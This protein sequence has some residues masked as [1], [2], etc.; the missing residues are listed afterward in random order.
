MFTDYNHFKKA[1]QILFSETCSN[2]LKLSQYRD[3]VAQLVGF[4]NQQSI[5]TYFESRSNG[6][7]IVSVI[8]YMNETIHSKYDFYDDPAGNRK[9]EE[10][11]KEILQN[12]MPSYTVEDLDDCLDNGYFEDDNS[13]YQLFITHSY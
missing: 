5:K 12:Y 3:R 8:T 11:F 7:Q 13:D 2:G 4:S 1:T 10:K 9:A 6:P